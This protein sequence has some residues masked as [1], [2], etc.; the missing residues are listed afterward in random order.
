MREPKSNHEWQDFCRY[1]EKSRRYVLNKEWR[2]F[3]DWIEE[4][5]NRYAVVAEKDTLFYR[6][7]PGWQIWPDE[8]VGT[9]DEGE[10]I[11]GDEDGPLPCGE[12][13]ASPPEKATGGRLNPEGIP[14]LY[15]A[16]REKTAIAEIRPWIDLDLT[17]A[18]FKSVA[19]L[20]IVDTSL[21]KGIPDFLWPLR[22][23]PPSADEVAKKIW[24]D[25]NR[26]MAKPQ[27]PNGPAT[28]CLATQYLAEVFKSAGFDGVAYKS[29]VDA[30][31]DGYNVAVFSTDKLQCFE[32]RLVKVEKI[33]YT[34]SDDAFGRTPAFFWTPASR[35]RWLI[36]QAINTRANQYSLT[37]QGYVQVSADCRERMPSAPLRNASPSR[38]RMLLLHD[39]IASSPSGQEAPRADARY[40]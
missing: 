33:K 2:A 36:E 10:D 22:E 5:A 17:V 14:C 19:P 15:V 20:R 16:M 28:R 11:F 39:K 26:A 38:Q 6:C 12:M 23:Q 4:T 29:S 25:I 21:E 35:A 8:Y 27:A 30:G 37:R 3:I 1:I 7:R 9:N 18:K 13:W 40:Q 32:S 34:V 24:G 31:D